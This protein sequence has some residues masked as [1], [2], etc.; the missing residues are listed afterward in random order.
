MFGRNTTD[1][2]LR[3]VVLVDL[4]RVSGGENLNTLFVLLRCCTRATQGKQQ[5]VRFATP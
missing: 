4:I 2:G 5:L 3:D 1:L